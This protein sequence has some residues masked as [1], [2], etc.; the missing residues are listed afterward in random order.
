M[1]LGRHVPYN[2]ITKEYT[3][4]AVIE[5]GVISQ[6]AAIEIASAPVLLTFPTAASDFDG[7]VMKVYNSTAYYGQLRLGADADS[8]LLVL[9][10]GETVEVMCINYIGALT[11]RAY[12]WM[13]PRKSVVRKLDWTPTLTWGTATPTFTSD[14]E[15]YWMN[16]LVVCFVDIEGTNG[17]AVLLIKI[18]LVHND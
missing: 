7:A 18:P 8:E 5:P 1:Y 4:S 15:A 13:C 14:Y 10:P 17:F 9:A 12:K 2:L 3:S 16:G 11:R 6:Y